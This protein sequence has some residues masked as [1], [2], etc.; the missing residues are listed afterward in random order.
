MEG[1]KVRLMVLAVM[2]LQGQQLRKLNGL[3]VRCQF[4]AL[5]S[6]G[7]L[8]RKRSVL[9]AGSPS[10]PIREE[11]MYSLTLWV[12]PVILAACSATHPAAPAPKL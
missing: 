9:C 10:S 1:T 4:A 3:V 2:V 8:S 11:T 5:V 12:A 7:T 6:T